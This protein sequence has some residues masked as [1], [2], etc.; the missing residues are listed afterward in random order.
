MNIDTADLI[1]LKNRLT[2][3][4]LINLLQTKKLSKW[5]VAK[6]CGL[7]YRTILNWVQNKVKPST[8][9]AIVV[10]RYFNLIEVDEVERRKEIDELQ[11]K[12]DRLA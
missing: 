10:G 2:G 3:D 8:D 11:K 9:N 7:S 4:N 1:I 5:R 6:D 12:I